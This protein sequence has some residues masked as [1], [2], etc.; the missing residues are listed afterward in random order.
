MKTFWIIAVLLAVAA[1]AFV[2]PSLLARTRRSS[3][4]S[5]EANVALYRE[6]IAELN[7]G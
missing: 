3:A 4:T 7:K 5:R 1:L 2:L 6:Q